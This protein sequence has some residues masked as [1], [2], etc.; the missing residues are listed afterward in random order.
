M[1]QALNEITIDSVKSLKLKTLEVI[2]N[3]LF[4]KRMKHRQKEAYSLSFTEVSVEDITKSGN[5]TNLGYF[6]RE[7]SDIQFID[8]DE[9]L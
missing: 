2:K 5:K 9:E 6:E 8:A 3:P 4:E 7:L 1:G